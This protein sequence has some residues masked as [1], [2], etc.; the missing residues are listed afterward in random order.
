[1]MRRCPVRS[2]T[3]VGDLAQT[4]DAAGASSWGAVL[5]PYVGRDWR[6]EE[7][8][9]NYRTPA[10]ITA[11]ADRVLAAIDPKLTA[12]TSVRSTGEEPWWLHAEPEQLAE[13][14]AHAAAAE[15]AD[16]GAA[17]RHLAV[18]VPDARYVEMV[19][20]VAGQLA[21]P[22]PLD[23][24]DGPVVVL[25]V[26][27]AKGLEFDSVILVEPDTIAAQ[28]PRG[29]NDLYVALTRATQRLGVI[30]SGAVPDFAPPGAAPGSGLW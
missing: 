1:V 30:Y 24:V 8:T 20:A 5:R 9:V 4:S 18:L 11:V 26:R 16:G 12:P 21:V 2:M 25:T 6:F 14:T 17:G 29:R 13:A 27:Q 3:L 28:S 23:D 22:E 7:L 10:E 19:T 15:A